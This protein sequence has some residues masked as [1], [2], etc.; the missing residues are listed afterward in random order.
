MGLG[1]DPFVVS[2]GLI[3]GSSAGA[4][5]VVVVG[6]DCT[7]TDASGTVFSVP[8]AL[9]LL[10]E[11]PPVVVLLRIGGDGGGPGGSSLATAPSTDLTSA[12]L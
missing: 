4:V 1:D 10:G 6:R 3:A 2:T 9:G 7:N 11:S 5:V 8:V 12:P